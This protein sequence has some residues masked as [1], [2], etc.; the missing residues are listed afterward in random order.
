MNNPELITTIR[1][2]TWQKY[3]WIFLLKKHSLFKK[4]NLKLIYRIDTSIFK[5]LSRIDCAFFKQK[6]LRVFLLIYYFY[7]CNKF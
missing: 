7:N 1:V 4:K 3:H 2:V 6:Y 5:I